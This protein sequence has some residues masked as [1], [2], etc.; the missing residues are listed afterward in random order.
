MGLQ[1]SGAR[2]T[3]ANFQARRL[4]DNSLRN[5]RE[6]FDPHPA[7]MAIYEAQWRAY[8]ISNNFDRGE[9]EHWDWGLKGKTFHLNPNYITFA[10]ESGGR[11]QGMMAVK[12]PNASYI[13]FGAETLYVD[14]IEV[15]PWN[16]KNCGDREFAGLGPM[17]IYTAI[18]LSEALGFNGRLTLCALPSAESFYHRIGMVECGMNA[19][20]NPPLRAFEFDDA[21]A[22]GFLLTDERLT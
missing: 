16:R 4:I 6:L 18:R 2:R 9:S 11:C 7:T 10:L 21:T 1:S 15:A 3:L 17:L 22:A 12:W 19:G 8:A 5:F 13:T 14:Y 20:Y